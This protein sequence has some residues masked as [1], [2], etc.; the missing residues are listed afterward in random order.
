M[1]LE[2]ISNSLWDRADFMLL[3]AFF[4][5]IEGLSIRSIDGMCREEEVLLFTV[6][7]FVMGLF[8]KNDPHFL[9]KRVFWYL[10][11]CNLFYKT[12]IIYI[13]KIY[14]LVPGLQ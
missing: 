11:V 8:L 10:R 5:L 7:L 4:W 13:N 1:N 14:C 12:I 2:P 3:F 6:F 9:S